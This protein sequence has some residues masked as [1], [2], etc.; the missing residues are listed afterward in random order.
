MASLR[1][2][3]G[4]GPGTA[5]VFAFPAFLHP[6]P[7]ERIADHA[8]LMCGVLADLG[9]DGNV[10]TWWHGRYVPVAADGGGDSLFLDTGA[11]GRLGRQYHETGVLF[12]G[13][14]SLAELLEQT[15]DALHGTGPL[16]DQYR[17]VVDHGVLDWR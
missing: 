8:E 1:R 3:D 13:P 17:P 4:V 16:A 7:A 12:E 2:H 11:E 15:A 5:G 14:A 9:I 10:G 6:L